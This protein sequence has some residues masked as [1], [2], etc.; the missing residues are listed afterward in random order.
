MFKLG[1]AFDWTFR[2]L[3]LGS[4]IADFE[5]RLATGAF[6]AYLVALFLRYGD[7]RNSL[8]SAR[9]RGRAREAAYGAFIEW[10]TD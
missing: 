4:W 7:V 3:S 9:R 5:A 10:K 8:G 6:G 2:G 1:L